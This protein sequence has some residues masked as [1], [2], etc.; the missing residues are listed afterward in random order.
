MVQYSLEDVKSCVRG[1]YRYWTGFLYIDYLSI[2]ITWFFA[3]F[4]R[5]TPN[6]VTFIHFVIRLGAVG[7]F[8][9]GT[10]T[11]L[12]S[13]ALLYQLSIILDD[14]D[15]KLARVKGM[16]SASGKYFDHIC[17]A[18]GD[19][20]C[21]AVLIYLQIL[22]NPQSEMWNMIGIA[23]PFLYLFVSYES[24][25]FN[26]IS[27]PIARLETSMQG[28]ANLSPH[29]A[30][31]KMNN[32][33]LGKIRQFSKEIRISLV[34]LDMADVAILLFVVGPLLGKVQLMIFVGLFFMVERLVVGKMIFYARRTNCFW[35]VKGS[36]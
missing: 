8:C 5:F 4:T 28:Q 11:S 22:E 29:D 13:G 10:R 24:I 3:N 16:S 32:F 1:S 36:N 7:A 9:G 26:E 27:T 18:I 20:L 17:D 25:L 15:G 19:F 14:V 2:R 34:T 30:S 12:F 33:P 35:P 21:L 23:M 31:Q 6:Q